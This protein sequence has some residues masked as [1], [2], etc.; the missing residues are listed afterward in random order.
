MCFPPNSDLLLNLLTGPIVL[1]ILGY[2]GITNLDTSPFP[3]IS[4]VD[5]FALASYIRTVSSIKTH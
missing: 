5:Y 2:I 1:N 4:R 3:L